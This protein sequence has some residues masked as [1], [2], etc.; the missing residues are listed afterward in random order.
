MNAILRLIILTVG[1]GLF[2]FAGSTFLRTCGTSRIYEAKAHPLLKEENILIAIRGGAK[3]NPENTF[4]AFDHAK[5]QG[6]W[7]HFDLRLTKDNKLIVMKDISLDRTTDT[8]GW[9]P[10]KT[11]EELKSVKAGREF[12]ETASEP[13]PTFEEMLERYKDTILIIELQDN[14]LAAINYII[15]YV[16]KRNMQE[17]VIL[18]SPHAGP[19]KETR[20]LK[21]EWLTLSSPD[22]VERLALLTS[23][24][25]ESVSTING[26]FLLSPLQ[27]GRAPLLSSAMTAEAHRR[28]KRIIASYINTE[29][30][31]RTA[32]ELNVDGIAT[33]RPALL[34][35]TIWSSST[36]Q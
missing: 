36:R 26:D 23:V 32:L 6:A 15:D 9:L 16:E 17:R 13:I 33:E 19:L 7:L 11:L 22:E 2:L 34:R 29:G 21:P 31:A 28:K 25:L 12:S 35:G 30:D 18:A 14:S 24:A 1:T 3:E 4:K 27:S 20:A 5:A 10:E 8:K